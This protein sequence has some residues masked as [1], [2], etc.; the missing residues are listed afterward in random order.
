MESTGATE[1]DGIEFED[2]DAVLNEIAGHLNAQHARLVDVTVALLADP[3]AWSGPGVERADQYLAWKTGLSPQRATQIVDIARRATELPVSMAA[4][5]HGELA[6]DQMAAVA[7]RAP[8]WADREVCDLARYAT[9]HQLRTA[10]GRYPFPDIPAP[11][12]VR[13]VQDTQASDAELTDAGPQLSPADSDPDVPPADISA[14]TDPAPAPDR[15][16][17][18]VGSDGRFR[19]NLECDELTGMTITTALREA[20]DHLFHDGHPGVDWTDALREIA[21]RSLDSIT[22]LARRDRYRIHVHL[23][24]DGSCTDAH[25]AN[26]PDTIRRHLTCD[27]L[28][29]ATFI[30]GSIPISVGRTGRVIPERTRRLVMLRDQGCGVPGCTSTHV[31][32]IHHIIHWEDGGPTDTWNLICLCPHHHRLHHRGELGITGNADDGTVA[33]TDQTGKPLQPTGA[34]PQPPGA[35]P[36]PPTGVYQHPLGERLDYQW[37]YFNPPPEHRPGTHRRIA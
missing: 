19:M 1:P 22:D 5:R 15:L 31:L 4:F 27:G 10:L 16:W 23:R 11:D 33:F 12:N 3:S 28:V 6:V 18:G 36:L 30:D 32:E 35:P 26:L 2:L 20:R 37:L 24:T 13:P 21:E 29:T 8:W 7:K 9:V 14:S 17:F 34:R 25:G